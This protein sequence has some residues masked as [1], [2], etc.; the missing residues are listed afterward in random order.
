MS[1]EYI[2]FKHTTLKVYHIHNVSATRLH[3]KAP[4]GALGCGYF[5]INTA[6]KCGDVMAIVRG[7]ASFDDM[8]NAKVQ[9]VSGK[10]AELGVTPG[11]TGREA[12]EKMC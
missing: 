3:N 5:D 2:N 1:I 10:A 12:L 7:V 6:N 9:E 11:I 8:M 4:N